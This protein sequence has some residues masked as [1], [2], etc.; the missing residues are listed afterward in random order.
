MKNDYVKTLGFKLI[1]LL[2]T[3]ILTFF[4]TIYIF[5]AQIDKLKIQI[6]NIFFG[7]LVPVLKLQEVGKTYKD[8][9][10]CIQN[11]KNC[12]KNIYINEI[13]KN[14]TYY[15][16]TYKTIKEK[17][18]VSAVNKELE[19]SLKTKAGINSYKLM[20]KKINFLI[21]YEIEGAY[22]ERRIFLHAYSNMK[23]YLLY[24]L[25]TLVLLAFGIILFIIISII[26]KDKDLNFLNKKYKN[27]SITDGM[28]K[29]NNRKHFDALFDQMP[30]IS[31][32]NHWQ[33][34]FIMCDIDHF[35]QYN[36]TYGHDKG[37]ETLKAVA[38]VLK[39]YFNKEYEYVFRL[40]GEE[41]GVLLFDTHKGILEQCLQDI[42][43]NIVKL[44][45]EHKNSS[46]LEVLSISMGAVIYD[47]R[48]DLSSN[49]MYKLADQ[50]LYESKN[51]G[52]N[53]Y[54]L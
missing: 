15:N 26:K 38:N 34:A 2:T 30:K 6:D 18:V 46:V 44:Q 42:N 1:V 12:N 32:D 35:K 50:K 11:S 19:R 27:E 22:K 7:N 36:D 43:N 10:I 45:I 20:L 5:N 52:R 53:K 49:Q 29:L 54:T 25:I 39:D 17:N 21:D 14:W 31:K 23:G 8:L 16:K 4:T 51:S 47:S 37:D 33:S 40:G 9:I 48:Q 13:N 24:S 28:T 41:F 3:V